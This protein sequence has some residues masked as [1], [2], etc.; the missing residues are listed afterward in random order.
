[1]KGIIHILYYNSIGV[2]SQII[3][4]G[5]DVIAGSK[6]IEV[7]TAFKGK[8][9]SFFFNQIYYEHQETSAVKD[10]D[11][12]AFVF[13][14]P[15]RIEIWE[16]E[17]PNEPKLYFTKNNGWSWRKNNSCKLESIWKCIHSEDA[18]CLTM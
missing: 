18:L 2:K 6:K 10:W 11:H 12:L 1:M 7:K 3:K 15:E 8:S 4:K 14:S 16:C 17:R 9:G 13:V 5:H